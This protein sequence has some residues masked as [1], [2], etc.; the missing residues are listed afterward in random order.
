MLSKTKTH[1]EFIHVNRENTLLMHNFQSREVREKHGLQFSNISYLWQ[2]KFFGRV[3]VLAHYEYQS[4]FCFCHKNVKLCNFSKSIA[5][6]LLGSLA[7][8]L[9]QNKI[10]GRV[11]VMRFG[12]CFWH[13]NVKLSN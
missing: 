7:I 13:G 12:F 10:F 8:Y 4:G 9:W 11:D 1:C 3:D 2:N 5:I 6:V